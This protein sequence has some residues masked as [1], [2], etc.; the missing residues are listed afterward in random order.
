MT[1]SQRDI[2]AML[3]MTDRVVRDHVVPKLRRFIR[4]PGGKYR[5]Y[6][7]DDVLEVVKEFTYSI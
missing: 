4:M 5:Y 1:I 2:A 6:F 7:I 3:G